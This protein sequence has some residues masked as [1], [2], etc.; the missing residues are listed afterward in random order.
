MDLGDLFKQAKAMQEKAQALQDDLARVE[1]EG[2]SGGG[3]VRVTM[4]GKFEI[5]RVHID[6][7]FLKP[8]EQGVVEDLIVAASNDARAKAERAASEQ[9]QKL[10]A[11]LGLPPGF[12]LPGM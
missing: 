6:P 10:T 7:S 11:G 1:V 4:T 2:A 3:M 8:E 12:K 5:K 9:M